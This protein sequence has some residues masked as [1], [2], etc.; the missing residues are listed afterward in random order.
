MSN[1]G[2]IP[3]HIPSLDLFILRNVTDEFRTSITTYYR[4]FKLSA[5]NSCRISSLA[6]FSV[7]HV[8]STYATVLK[9]YAAS[10]SSALSMLLFE[11]SI[12]V[13]QFQ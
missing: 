13:I 11:L 7:P 1:F 6:C 2:E 8:L 5:R 9:G 10:N 3:F 4:L 12:L